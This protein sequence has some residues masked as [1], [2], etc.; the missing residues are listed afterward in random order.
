[1]ITD[2]LTWTKYKLLRIEENFYTECLRNTRK[3]THMI[4]F[5]IDF[6]LMFLNELQQVGKNTHHQLCSKSN[7]LNF[8]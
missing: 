5:I 3:H 8:S 4:V 1:M 6:L 2:T 7:N